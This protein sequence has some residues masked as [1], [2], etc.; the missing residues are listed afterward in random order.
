MFVALH[1]PNGGGYQVIQV[2]YVLEY[3]FS[4]V[5]LDDV[6]PVGGTGWCGLVGQ[7]GLV[8]AVPMEDLGDFTVGYFFLVGKLFVEFLD[9]LSG[10]VLVPDCEVGGYIEGVGAGLPDKITGVLVYGADEEV[11]VLLSWNLVQ[12]LPDVLS[13]AA[14]EGQVG[15]GLGQ[16]AAIQELLDPADQGP[17]L[18]GARAAGDYHW[19]FY[20]VHCASLRPVKGELS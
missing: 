2:Q 19:T 15:Y 3:L 16:C 1:C 12:L 6:Q 14:A 20:L 8:Q 10:V 7:S 5:E 13:G 17:G 11:L 9:C 4:V 18:P